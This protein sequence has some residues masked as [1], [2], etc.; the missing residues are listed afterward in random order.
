MVAHRV[1]DRALGLPDAV[2]WRSVDI[3]HAGGPGDG[4][5]LLGGLARDIDPTAAQGRA[6][7]PQLGD[8][9]LGAADPT[10][11]KLGHRFLLV[12][13]PTQGTDMSSDSPEREPIY[14]ARETGARRWR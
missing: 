1:T 5:D 2:E 13:P 12:R 6:A 11:R 3:A 10:L 9:K 14:T 8:L 4:D 7:E